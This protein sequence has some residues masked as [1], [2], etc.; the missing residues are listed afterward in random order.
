M[1]RRIA[2]VLS[3]AVA[4]GAAMLAASPAWAGGGCHRTVTAE[5]GQTVKMD[6][7]CFV[8]GVIHAAAGKAVR[9]VN[10]SDQEHT[11]TALGH[12]WYQNLAPGTTMAYRFDSE[13]VYPFFCEI[14]P[15]MIGAVV[16][17]DGA[18]PGMETVVEAPPPPEPV[19]E[20]AEPVDDAA[21]ETV[22][23]TLTGASGG[24][25]GP[26]AAALAIGAASLGFGA[27]LVLR[28]RP[29]G[30]RVSATELREAVP[31]PPD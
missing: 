2:I 9:F 1:S 24:S 8:P 6:A 23:G 25:S 7:N 17:G 18:V 20:A 27:G 15:G 12:E 10:S 26:R 22:D 19:D 28:G 14:H 29:R 30:V 3:F 16:V 31:Q 11:V 13:G 5:E 4:L 21:E